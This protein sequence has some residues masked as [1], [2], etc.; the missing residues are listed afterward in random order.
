MILSVSRRT[1]IPAFYMEWFLNRQKAGYVLTRNPMNRKQIS[2]IFFKDVECYVFWTKNPSEIVK[3]FNDIDKPFMTQVTLTPYLKDVE[4]GLED[5]NAV[6]EAMVELSKLGG[7]SRLIWRYDPIIINDKYTIDY[8]LFYFEKLCKRLRGSVETCIISFVEFYKKIEK[9]SK[10]FHRIDDKK[11]DELA[12][13]LKKIAGKYDIQLKSCGSY[14]GIEKAAC[15]D[16]SIIRDM[17]ITGYNKDKYQR[18]DCNCL[19]SIDIGAYNTCVHDCTYCYA[20]YNHDSAKSFY[21]NFDQNSEILG[22]PLVGDEIIRD[23]MIKKNNQISL[24]E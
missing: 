8:H 10:D 1:D 23:K 17:G 22:P 11:K 16:E 15:I 3:H 20:N 14:D 24:F 12:M 5:K 4:K 13:T 21:R 2:R 7:K 9:A 6:I 18:K 19:E